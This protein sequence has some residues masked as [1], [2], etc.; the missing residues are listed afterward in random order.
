MLTEPSTHS[1]TVDIDAHDWAEHG[2]DQEWKRKDSSRFG[3]GVPVL[4]LNDAWR[5]DQVSDYSAVETRTVRHDQ[6][7]GKT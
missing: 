5:N 6:P 4:R 2:A 7:E 3:G 1:T